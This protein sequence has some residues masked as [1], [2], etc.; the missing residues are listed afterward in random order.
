[1]SKTQANAGME[2]LEKLIEE[3]FGTEPGTYSTENVGTTSSGIKYEIL[4]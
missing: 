4:P 2:Q 3:A 1:M